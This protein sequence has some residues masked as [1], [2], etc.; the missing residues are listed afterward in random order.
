MLFE[1]CHIELRTAHVTQPSR[2]LS[3]NELRRG[4][5][6]RLLTTC[7]NNIVTCSI[8]FDAHFLVLILIMILADGFT[9]L[10]I[11]NVWR[12]GGTREGGRVIVGWGF[13]AIDG[14]WVT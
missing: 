14:G 8:C 5:N 12:R 9:V 2:N 6:T 7:V 11:S 3:G 13:V 4:T 1:R 10:E